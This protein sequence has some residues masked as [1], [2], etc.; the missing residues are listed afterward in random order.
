MA[1]LHT[2][3]VGVGVG[4]GPVGRK[5]H[6]S[7]VGFGFWNVHVCRG[8]RSE[9]VKMS[10]TTQTNKD[11][12]DREAEAGRQRQGD[13]SR[14]TETTLQRTAFRQPLPKRAFNAG[15]EDEAQRGRSA[16][17]YDRAPAASTGFT[18]LLAVD[19]TVSAR[20]RRVTCAAED[21]HTHTHTHTAT[22]KDTLTSTSTAHTKRE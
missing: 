10:T 7:L 12:R 13:R 8:D 9:M 14:E 21:T 16:G 2:P 4:A 5:H 15:S 17:T 18:L 19:V 1:G 3:E 20:R 22:A 6:G 11:E